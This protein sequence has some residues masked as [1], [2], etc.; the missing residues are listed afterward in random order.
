M[1]H[2]FKAP[3]PLRPQPRR[4]LMAEQWDQFA[5]A[6]LSEGTPSI[7]RQEMRRAFYAGAESILFRVIQAFAPE[8]EP[9]QADLQV[10]SDLHK[11]LENFADA[12]KEGR[13]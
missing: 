5:R 7:Q 6:V 4:L 8:S 13:A 12:V 10:M 11:E 1:S 9:T 2:T 3:K